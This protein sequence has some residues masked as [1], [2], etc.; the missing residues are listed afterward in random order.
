MEK[1]GAYAWGDDIG[2]PNALI[3]AATAAT[4]LR[5]SSRKCRRAADA[6]AAVHWVGVGGKEE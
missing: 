1:I 5:N 2:I 6:T 3:V 4:I